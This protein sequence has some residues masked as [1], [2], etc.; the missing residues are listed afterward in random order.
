MTTEE[1]IEEKLEKFEYRFFSEIDDHIGNKLV[2]IRWLRTVLQEAIKFGVKQEKKKWEEEVPIIHEALD[3]A[4]KD[5]AVEKRLKHT[6]DDTDIEEAMKE[7]AKEERAA[8]LQEIPSAA[9]DTI[10]AGKI[11]NGKALTIR[12]LIEK[13]NV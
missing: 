1:F 9:L 10:I 12:S 2:H 13:R 6:V 3:E 4:K 7:G 5:G 11:S 8:I